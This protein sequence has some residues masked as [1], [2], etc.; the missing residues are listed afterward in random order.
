MAKR[1]NLNE[2]RQAVRR[3]VRNAQAKAR[4]LQNKGITNLGDHS[5]FRSAD[6]GRYNRAQLAAYSREL[7]KF[8]DR[9]SKF[10]PDANG[11]AVSEGV[12]QR[13]VT[14]ARQRRRNAQ[15]FFRQIEDYQMPGGMSIGTASEIMT[16]DRP[17]LSN[18]SANPIKDMEPR[19]PTSFASEGAMKKY[20]K[21]LTKQNQKGHLRTIQDQADPL[22]RKTLSGMK[23]AD[24]RPLIDRYKA[25]SPKQIGMLWNIRAAIDAASAYSELDNIMQSDRESP[26]SEDAMRNMQSAYQSDMDKMIAS[27]ENPTRRGKA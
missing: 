12:Y 13:Y 3:Q 27:V 9:S 2:Q 24:G 15:D 21:S 11:R 17:E 23:G 7:S 26:F 22:M 8:T 6:I 10:V 20:I 25:L 1:N 5:P 4:R 16:P 18:P 14:L 19:K